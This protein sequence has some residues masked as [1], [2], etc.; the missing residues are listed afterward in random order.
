MEQEEWASSCIVTSRQLHGVTPRG[1]FGGG[2]EQ[3]EGGAL[4]L[5]GG[6]QEQKEGELE[7][8]GESTSK[9]ELEQEVENQSKKKE[10]NWNKKE[11]N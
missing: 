7:Q 5:E 1:I 6:E 4:E 9:R 2:E 8:E 11:E 10:E 3:D